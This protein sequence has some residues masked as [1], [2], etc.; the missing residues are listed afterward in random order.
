M[1]QRS[2]PID[3]IIIGQGLAG[4]ALAVHLLKRSK[5]ILVID[6][7]RDN[8]ASR[9]AAGLFNPITG[10]KMVK[11]WMVDKLFPALHNHYRDAEAMT[12]QKFFHPMPLYRPF[13]S[14]EEQN[15]W[16]AK[17]ADATFESYIENVFTKSTYPDVN[18]PFGG[19]LLKQCGYLDTILYLD[20]VTKLIRDEGTFLEETIQD[21]DIIV[22]DDGV[23]YKNFEASQL[24]CCN[25]VHTNR[26]FSWLPIRPLKGETIHIETAYGKELIINRGVYVVPS[27]NAGEWRV[28][29][30]YDYQDLE[31][32]I[33]GK[34]GKEL[35]EKTQ[36]L[37]T[38]PFNIVS[39]EYGFRPT[40][41][42]RRPILG[43]HP[44][45]DRLY[46]LNGLGTKGVSLAPFFSQVLIDFIENGVPLNKDVDIERY[47]L[48]YWSSPK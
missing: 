21:D 45:F 9:I 22:N 34:A 44:E 13:I 24:I 43:R 12:G 15:E 48:L 3:Y 26:W 42:D 11:S 28:G 25:G 17:S 46:I 27:A 32:G 4:S 41:P 37:V 5:K 6:Q 7:P 8:R 36:E 2:R 20:A 23:R 47:K 31:E 35:A 38:F 30:T 10:R 18:D 39:Q 33:T 1:T 40:T 29:A 19:M 14:V 16:M